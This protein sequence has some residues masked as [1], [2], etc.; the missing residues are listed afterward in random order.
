MG[1]D[2]QPNQDECYNGQNYLQALRPFLFQAVFAPSPLGRGPVAQMANP[3]QHREIQQGANRSHNQHWNSDSI[4]MPSLRGC[5]D[6]AGGCQCRKPDRHA[7]PA[8]RQYRGTKTLQQSKHCT[9]P[10]DPPQLSYADPKAAGL[11]F[12]PCRSFVLLLDLHRNA[13][14][15]ERSSRLDARQPQIK[16]AH[17]RG[18]SKCPP[19]PF[20]RKGDRCKEFHFHLAPFPCN[21]SRMPVLQECVQQIA[22][23]PNFPTDVAHVN[24]NRRLPPP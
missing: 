6:T 21:L 9:C 4:L 15:S 20:I 1:P 8:D 11:A 12:R 10:A 23:H 13:P 14:L 17:A 16:S 22:P 18:Q 2:F 7:N 5:V 19:V 3:G 24:N